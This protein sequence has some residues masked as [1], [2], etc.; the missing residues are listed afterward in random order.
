M[1]KQLNMQFSGRIGPLVGCQRD[2]KYYYR[3]RPKKF[4]QT[5]ATQ[6]AAGIFGLAAMACKVMRLYLE[7]CIPNPKDQPMRRQLEGRIRQWLGMQAS[8][9]PQ[10]TA[11]I[12]FVNHFNFNE[13]HRLSDRLTLTPI[14]SISG[15]G[16]ALLQL[17][18]FVPCRQ[19][20]APAGA[21]HLQLTIGSVA[22]QLDSYPC[23]GSSSTTISLPYDDA[24]Q[25]A[26]EFTLPLQSAP[27]HILIAAMQLRYGVQEGAEI[28]YRKHAAKAVAAI[29]GAI[30]V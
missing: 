18:A 12:P 20:K 15:A 3:S 10:S 9:P 26:Q 5:A 7:P 11:D 24:L 29:V 21:T 13:D 4:R 22:L 1:A 27:G 2:G 23:F 8:L 14:F 28:S 6:K 19:V 25:P 17:P 30:Y 16:T